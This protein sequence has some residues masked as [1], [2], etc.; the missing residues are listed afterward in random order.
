V[1]GRSRYGSSTKTVDEQQEFAWRGFA[2]RANGRSQVNVREFIQR[3]YSAYEGD[4]SFLQGSTQ[5]TL[6]IWRK[7]QPLLA[8]EREKEVLDVSQIPSGIISH[9]PGY[10]D[11]EREIIVGLQTEAPLKRA[12]MLSAAGAWLR[13]ASSLTAMRPDERVG[14]IF[15]SIGKTHNDGVSMPTR[16]KS[17]KPGPRT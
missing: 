15:T 3:N 11:K 5:R 17:G 1:K 6:D 2:A 8:E 16:P 9:E 14:E 4:H 13:R 7:L 10:I 12:I